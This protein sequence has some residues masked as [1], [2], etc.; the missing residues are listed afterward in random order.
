[1][2]L[3][4]TGRIAEDNQ[5]PGTVQLPVYEQQD[6]TGLVPVFTSHTRMRQ[7]FP[8]ITEHQRMPL[9]TL[10]QLLDRGVD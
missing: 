3:I 2:V 1:M 8:Q 5:R 10:A 9:G 4:P 7:A 6:G